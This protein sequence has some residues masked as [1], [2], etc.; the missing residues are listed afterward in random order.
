M[1]GD[2][3]CQVLTIMGTPATIARQITEACERVAG[4]GDVDRR[5]EAPDAAGPHLVIPRRVSSFSM[6]LL[7]ERNGEY[8]YQVY[9][10]IQE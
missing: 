6:N 5:W 4:G 8:F 3:W 10:L 9:F 7:S 2:T 1:R